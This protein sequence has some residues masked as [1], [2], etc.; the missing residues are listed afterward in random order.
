M[1][2]LFHGAT[3]YAHDYETTEAFSIGKKLFGLWQQSVPGLRPGHEYVLVQEFARILKLNEWFEWMRDSR[4]DK[5]SVT[6]PELLKAKE[7][8]A[9]M[10][11]LGALERFDKMDREEV[12]RV[13]AEIALRGA[14]GIDYSSAESKYYL[15]SL[16]GAAFSGLRLLCLMYVAFKKTEPSL[17]LGLDLEGPYQMALKLYQPKQG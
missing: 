15:K 1:D 5:Q 6:N 7:P 3:S 12:G 9:A 4:S 8:A 13:A 14:E 11:C 2:S 16:P 17:D 10:Y